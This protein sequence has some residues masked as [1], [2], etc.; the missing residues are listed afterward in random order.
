MALPD[1]ELVNA[2]RARTRRAG[3]LK[4]GPHV[5]HFQRLDRVP[6]ELEF[7]GHIPHRPKLTPSQRK[8]ALKRREA[9]ETLVD[10]ARTTTIARL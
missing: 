10:I 5:L 6:V 1:R 4:L 8:N 2:D 9:G 7:L 3:T